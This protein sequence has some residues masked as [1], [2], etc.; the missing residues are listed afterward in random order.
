MLAVTGF[1]SFFI[2]KLVEYLSLMNKNFEVLPEGINVYEK[3]NGKEVRILI[4]LSNKWI[5]IY[6]RLGNLVEFPDE[7]KEELLERLLRINWDYAEV[8]FSIDSEG[9]I[10]SV[11]DEY[12]HAFY[13]DVFEQEYNAVLAS[14][15]LF[16]ATK[17]EILRS[18]SAKATRGE[19]S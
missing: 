15:K 16:E 11:Q 4:L 6:A 8:N 3:I 19:R 13:Y 2:D 18:I 17:E 1:E 12:I 14:V 5:R 10:C 9:N 7:I